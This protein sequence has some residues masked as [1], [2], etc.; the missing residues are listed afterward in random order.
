MLPWNRP[1]ASGDP[2]SAITSMVIVVGVMPT[3]V[4]CNGTLHGL[5]AVVGVPA[6]AVVADAAALVV[7]G[8]LVPLREHAAAAR[9]MT[10]ST[11]SHVDL[12]IWPPLGPRTRRPWSR[13]ARPRNAPNDSN[14][15]PGPLRPGTACTC[16]EKNR[17][18]TGHARRRGRRGARAPHE[19]DVVDDDAAAKAPDHVGERVREAEQEMTERGAHQQGEGRIP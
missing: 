6:A 3:S 14:P 13:G 2:T 1:G 4:A 19:A 16:P 8:W 10:A 17:V 15:F 5:A 12:R 11:A 18:D 7:A 9:A